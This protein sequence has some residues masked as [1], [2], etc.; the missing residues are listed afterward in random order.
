MGD[1]G[2]SG[3]SSLCFLSTKTLLLHSWP[4]GIDGQRLMSSHSDGASAP[5][6]RKDSKA[7]GKGAK[8]LGNSV[9][10]PPLRGG[11]S[12]TEQGDDGQHV[13]RLVRL[14][15]LPRTRHDGFIHTT[16]DRRPVE[17]HSTLTQLK[18]GRQS[19]AGEEEREGGRE[20][21]SVQARPAGRRRHASSQ[22]QR[23]CTRL[24]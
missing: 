4:L 21:P 10:L 15:G 1:A 16:D 5:S 8:S 6:S 9:S 18:Q 22:R 7:F 20:V 11:A 12:I 13:V 2:N 24:V 17:P 19:V 23:A 3:G 14:R